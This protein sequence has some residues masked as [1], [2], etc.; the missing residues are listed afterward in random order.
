MTPRNLFDPST[1]RF[2][3]IR[4]WGR[5]TK[6]G[7]G[8]TIA[9]AITDSV[10]KIFEEALGESVVEIMEKTDQTVKRGRFDFA[11]YQTV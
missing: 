7:Y 9:E 5:T 1:S 2:V 8:T 4:E 10:C 3:A 6:Y 11:V